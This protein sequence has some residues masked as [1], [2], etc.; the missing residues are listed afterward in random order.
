MATPRTISGSTKD[1]SIT[2]F[3][4]PDP[5]PCH[6]SSPMANATPSGTVIAIVAI[7]RRR[8]WKMAAW[9]SGSWKSELLGSPH[10]QLRPR[11]WID[12]LERP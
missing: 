9:S 10:H 11:P 8:L 6:R 12:A 1:K 3:A 7:D 5:R 2:K 4:V